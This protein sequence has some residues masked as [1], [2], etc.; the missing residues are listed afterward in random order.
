MLTSLWLEYSLWGA[1]NTQMIHFH[2]YYTFLEK[3]GKFHI[4]SVFT[5]VEI[6]TKGPPW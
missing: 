2:P 5:K 4:F 6:N 3:H 1:Q